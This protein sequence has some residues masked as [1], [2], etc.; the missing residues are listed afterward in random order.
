VSVELLARLF[1][2]IGLFLLG[3]RLMTDGL[4]LAAGQALREILAR[5]TRT[6]L[7]GIASG[8]LVTSLVQSSSAIT[9]ATI[10]FVNAGLLNLGQALAVTYGSNIGTTTTGWL[11][12]AVGFHVNVRA[13]ALPLIGIG[14]AL[15]IGC[16][17][18]WLGHLGQALAGFGVFFLGID[19]LREGFEGISGQIEFGAL[20]GAGIGRALGFVVVGFLLTVLMQSSSAAIAIILTAVGGG[21]IPM[22]SG[23]ALVIGAN[24]GTTSTAALAVIGATPSAK[25]VAAGHVAFNLITG[26]VALILLPA[27]LFAIVWTRDL[28]ELDSG[29]AAVLAGFHTLFNLLGVALLMPLTPRLLRLLEGWFR[30]SEED[31]ARPRYLDA[32]V[33]LTPLLA[34]DAL[35]LEL[36]RA[37]QI[38]RRIAAQALSD[39]PP[40]ESIAAGRRALDALVEAIGEFTQQLQRTDVPAELDT[41]SPTTLRVARYY[42]E[43]AELADTLAQ[44]HAGLASTLRSAPRRAELD[45]LLRRARALIEHAGIEHAAYGRAAI[46]TE[47]DEVRRTYQSLKDAWLEAGSDGRLPV[48]S[49]VEL[50]DWLSNVHRLA[51]QIERGTR[52]LASLRAPVEAEAQPEPENRDLSDE[53]D[54]ARGTDE[55]ASYEAPSDAA[56]GPRPD[57]DPASQ[58]ALSPDEVRGPAP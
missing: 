21:V 12:A 13:F 36:T 11:V 4:R 22:G 28:L 16:R 58:P 40:R 41:L 43:A 33:R 50:L 20:V 2:G 57:S 1:G 39:P 23:A 17:G 24:V 30:T 38:A 47:L 10:G 51:E 34:R 35:V 44:A 3:M 46:G 15:R 53:R 52:H 37:S 26:I 9:V 6:R 25:R 55:V 54:G 31:E 49:L 56:K 32:N 5:S 27:L 29:A 7:R 14:M 42:V 19:T 48:R 8:F 45:D 18:G